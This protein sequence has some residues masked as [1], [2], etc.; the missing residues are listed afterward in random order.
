MAVSKKISTAARTQITVTSAV[1]INLASYLSGNAEDSSL[2][3]SDIW[4]IQVE[5]ANIRLMFDGNI[6]TA[7][8]GIRLLPQ[9]VI[10][11]RRSPEV[12]SFIAEGADAKVNIQAGQAVANF[13]S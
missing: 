9:Q 2:S 5:D 6:P 11:I 7:S 12:I 3:E 1:A 4:T 13:T 8:L 10:T